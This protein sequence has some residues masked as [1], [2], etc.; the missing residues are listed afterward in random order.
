MDAVPNGRESIL[1]SEGTNTVCGPRFIPKVVVLPRQARDRHRENSKQCRFLPGFYDVFGVALDMSL[2]MW[3]PGRDID[4][5][6]VA[7]PEYRAAAYSPDAGAI[8][9][10]LNGWIASGS[11]R[12][13]RATAPYGSP[14]G[15]PPLSGFPG[16]PCNF[17]NLS[18]KVPRITR[19]SELRPTFILPGGQ[20]GELSAADPAVDGDPEFVTRLYLSETHNLLLAARWNG[21]R[22]ATPTVITFAT[23]SADPDAAA[24]LKG[25]TH[26]VDIDAYTLTVSKNGLFEPFIHE[27]EHFTKTCSGQ[28]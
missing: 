2:V 23:A 12:A 20:L 18:S 15:K 16:V 22:P 4:A 24:A 28:T 7:I 1:S 11:D 10:A 8:E 21:S 5:M 27:N 25:V 26:A 6:R 19:W 9:T 3:Y 14:C 17:G 13:V